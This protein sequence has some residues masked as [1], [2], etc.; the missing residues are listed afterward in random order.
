MKPILYCVILSLCLFFSGCKKEEMSCGS[1]FG[2]AGGHPLDSL[3]LPYATTEGLNTMGCLINGEPWL[4]LKENIF[5]DIVY[6]IPF[7]LTGDGTLNLYG[8]HKNLEL[9]KNETLR[10][11]GFDVLSIGNYFYPSTTSYFVDFESCGDFSIDTTWA[12]NGFTI[13]HLSFENEIVSGTFEM[14]V[15]NPDCDTLTITNGRFDLSS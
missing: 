5:G 3:G 8:K 1:P 9:N 4:P 11:A 15:V 12:H 13:H 2:E 7:S 10:I 14:R 6:H